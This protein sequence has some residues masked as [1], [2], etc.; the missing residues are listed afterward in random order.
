MLTCVAPNTQNV[1][2]TLNSL[3]YATL[4]L[5][6]LKVGKLNRT[7]QFSPRNFDHFQTPKHKK[8]NSTQFKYF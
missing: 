5:D 7:Q 3:K 2:N 8:S 1:E 6:P 4:L